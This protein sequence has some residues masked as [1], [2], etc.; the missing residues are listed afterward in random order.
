MLMP[1]TVLASN[2]QH[3]FLVRYSGVDIFFAYPKVLNIKIFH[4]TTQQNCSE[5]LKKKL[6]I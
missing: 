2:R 6:S 1:P 4:F 5:D 3:W